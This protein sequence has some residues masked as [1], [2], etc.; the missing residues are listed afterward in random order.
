[1]YDVGLCRFLSLDPYVQAPDFIQ[2]FNRYSYCLNNLLVYTDPSGE[3]VFTLG[4]LIAAPFTGGAS[5]VLLPYAIGADIG[6][7]NAGT[8][9]NGTAN[10]FEWDYSSEKTWYYMGIGLAIGA[11]T[12]GAGTLAAD[13]MGTV[14]GG[15]AGG[16]VNGGGFGLLNAINS[17]LEADEL[18]NA[19]KDGMLRGAVTGL[20]GGGVSGAIGGG[21]GAFAGGAASNLSGQYLENDSFEEVNWISVGLSGASSYGA[22]HLSS[23][24]NWRMNVKDSDFNGHNINYRQYLRIQ[25]S[26]TRGRFWQSERAGGAFW[27]TEKGISRKGVTY[28]PDKKNVVRFD[29]SQKS[30][31]AWATFHPH[32][33]FE[34]RVNLYH[35]PDDITNVETSGIPSLIIN[36]G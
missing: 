5:L 17:E 14:A 18:W 29:F 12:A 10:P 11:G 15:I 4:V 27:L 19:T 20:V 7:W 32:P 36:M 2:N 23:Y 26:Y 33:Y 30:E 1:M 13:A 21:F 31:G 16:I 9:A 35:S 24:I 25:E 28:S 8:I 3:F 6:I 22:Y 34:S